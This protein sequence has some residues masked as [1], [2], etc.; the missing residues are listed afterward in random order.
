MSRGQENGEIEIDLLYSNYKD[1]FLLKNPN[2]EPLNKVHFGKLLVCFFLSIKRVGYRGRNA[3][4]GKKKGY[5]TGLEFKEQRGQQFVSETVIRQI[6]DKFNTLAHPH[7]VTDNF[8]LSM[9]SSI[10]A[11]GNHI[12]KE[13]VFKEKTWTLTVGGKCIP[14]DTLFISNE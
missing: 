5:Y 10:I 12:M 7:F 13:L 6:C 1:A 2:D 3:D 9:F 14:L 8:K 4:K 11:N